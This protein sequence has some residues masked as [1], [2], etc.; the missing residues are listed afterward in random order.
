MSSSVLSKLSALDRFL[1]IWIF[2]AM[3][4]GVALGRMFPTLG[5]TLDSYRAENVSLPIAFG[6]F[7]MMFPVLAKVKYERLGQLKTKR[8]LFVASLVLN[9]IIGP[10]LMFFLAY[11]FLPDMPHYRASLILIGLAR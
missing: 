5:T 10:L 3:A 7:W 11:L 9:W 2:A 8:S 4:C 6:L 1:P